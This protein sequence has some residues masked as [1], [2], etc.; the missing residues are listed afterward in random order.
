MDHALAAIAAGLV[1]LGGYG[2]PRCVLI[3]PAP[4]G[5]HQLI[6]SAP[7]QQQQPH[8]LGEP[9]ANA[10]RGERVQCGQKPAE[11]IAG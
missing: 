3:E 8:Q 7:R 6:D 9:P 10:G 1:S 4:V 11:L 5:R 2:E